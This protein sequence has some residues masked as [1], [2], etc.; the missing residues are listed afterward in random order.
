MSS[1]LTATGPPLFYAQP[2]YYSS[3][4]SLLSSFS[5]PVLA[6]L[7][8]FIAY[9]VTAGIFQIFDSSNW[10]WLDQY[11][12][13]DSAE[14][15][16][17]NRA[18]RLDVLVAVLIQQALQ[19]A[20]GLLW[21]SEAPEHVDHSATIRSIAHVL[22]S[23]LGIPDAAAAQFAYLLYW[24]LFPAVQLFVAMYVNFVLL[25]LYCLLISGG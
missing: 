14:V 17:R 6:V 1:N 15:A 16:S 24:W 19:T 11:R 25:P 7:A 10:A 9:W 12:I 22:V 8:P 13:H 3:S 20:L 2:F 21:I 5:D 18:S 4:P 23:A